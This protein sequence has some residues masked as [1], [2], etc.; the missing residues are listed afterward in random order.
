MK[1]QLWDRKHNEIV[2]AQVQLQ[3]S[4]DE[5]VQAETLWKKFR[6]DAVVRGGRKSVPDHNH[7]N[8]DEKSDDLKFTAYRCLG[9]WWEEEMQGLM[10]LSMLAVRGRLSD[11][12]SKPVLYIKYIEAAPWNLKSYVGEKA[13]FGGIGTSLI[14]AAIA[15]SVKEEFRGRIAL[16][17]LPQSE[18]FYSKI[19]QDLGIDK[20]VEKLRYFEMSESSAL[21]FLNEGD[22]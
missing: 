17:S 15:V 3:V 11:N 9:I 16:H 18:S 21:K 10:M 2:L 5:L 14:R 6:E 13:R 20:D 4:A 8:W 1:V 12:L 22:L 19:M 7:W